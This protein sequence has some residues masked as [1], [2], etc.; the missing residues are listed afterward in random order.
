MLFINKK[1]SCVITERFIYN[2][3]SIYSNCSFTKSGKIESETKELIK[4]SIHY[5][6]EN[7]IEPEFYLNYFDD[8]TDSRIIILSLA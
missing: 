4:L 2:I 1:H 7:N 5:L 8:K 3:D 6:S